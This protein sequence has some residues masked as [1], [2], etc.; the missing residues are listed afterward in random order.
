MHICHCICIRIHIRLCICICRRTCEAQLI[1]CGGSV[2]EAPPG[3]ELVAVV[4][5]RGG[6]PWVPASV[7]GCVGGCPRRR[8]SLPLASSLARRPPA[9]FE[10]PTNHQ[11]HKPTH[12]SGQVHSMKLCLITFG[13][14]DIATALLK[15][16][17]RVTL[18]TILTFIAGNKDPLTHMGYFPKVFPFS[19]NF[20]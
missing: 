13:F 1:F 18:I 10:R 19:L 2:E 6:V 12:F 11:K 17:I 20:S 9:S 16:L 8:R 4:S 3:T 7:G 5:C 15:S 14:D